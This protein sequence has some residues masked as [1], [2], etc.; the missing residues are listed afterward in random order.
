MFVVEDICGNIRDVARD[1]TIFRSEMRFRACE[2]RSRS[3]LGGG[4]GR[5]KS[6]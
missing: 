3:G 1:R 6:V 5:G 4:G 2:R